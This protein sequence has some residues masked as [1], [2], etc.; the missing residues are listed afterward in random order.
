M[1]IGTTDS[2]RGPT[3]LDLRDLVGAD[4]ADMSYTFV[5]AAMGGLLG[6]F[7]GKHTSPYGE[8]KGQLSKIFGSRAF[9]SSAACIHA[10][11]WDLKSP[12][13]TDKKYFQGLQKKF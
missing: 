7:A 10:A 11:A 6:C 13:N 2:V 5:M 3:L 4:T 12:A 8:L 9:L 1:S